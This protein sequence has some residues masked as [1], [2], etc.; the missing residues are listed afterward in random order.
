MINIKRLL[1]LTIFT[2]LT[3]TS[4]TKVFMGIY[5]IKSI[6]EVDQRTIL[7]YGK[8][9]NIPASD[10]YQLDTAYFSYLF[11]LDTIQFKEQI[12]NHYQPLQA[13]YYDNEGNLKSFQINCYAGGFPN[14]KWDRNEIFTS[15]LPKLQ[16]PIDSILP[17]DTHLKYLLPIATTENFSKDNYDFIVVVHWNRF[18]GRQSKRLIKFVQENEKLSEEKKVKILY[19]NSDNIFAKKDSNGSR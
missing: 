8:K 4:C 16:A 12:K 10:N 3:L 14:L 13:L 6:K 19:V 7:K 18:M 17:L 15:F 1:L 9:F 2:S 11:S 5:G